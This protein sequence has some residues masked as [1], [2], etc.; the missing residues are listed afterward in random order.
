MKLRV[1]PPNVVT[2]VVARQFAIAL[3]M[4]RNRRVRVP[5]R[6]PKRSL[7]AFA[8]VTGGIVAITLG[9]RPVFDGVWVEPTVPFDIDRWL[10]EGEAAVPELDPAEY[11][12]VLWHRE[13]GTRTDLAVVYL[14]GF[15]AD[16][17]EMRPVPRMIG[18]ALGANVFLARLE[19]HALGPAGLGAA[20]VQGWLDDTV[21]ALAVGEAIGDRV[22][23][24]GTSTGGTLATW[25]AMQ[26]EARGRLD[27]MVLVSPN[28]HPQNRLARL[29]LYPWGERIGRL[30]VGDEYCWEPMN[31]EQEEH[32]TTCYPTE[33]I[34]PMMTL[35]EH[36][37]LADVSTITVPTL[38]LY[39]PEDEIVDPD[40]TLRVVGEMSGT[41][42]ESVVVEGVTDRSKH[43]LAGDV[44]SP[45]TTEPVA[46]MIVE[47]VRRVVGGR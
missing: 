39:S 3:L 11:A 7:L 47:F 12:E 17:H 14:H 38:V 8:L 22:V 1:T 2:A 18:E 30:A 46:R 34:V 42:P 28:F 36:V 33:S 44:L 21:E 41:E 26:E 24:V 31:E 23:V 25:L 13:P 37:R 43:V 29:P 10:A 32:W 40:E 16:K 9:P 45:E 35:V 4:L 20:S 19:G 15:S 27:A 5:S 6:R